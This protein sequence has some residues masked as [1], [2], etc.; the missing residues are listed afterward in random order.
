[1]ALV[2]DAQWLKVLAETFSFVS[3]AQ[4][5][6]FE[7]ARIDEVLAEFA[8]N[9][10]EH[11]R[12]ETDILTGSIDFPPT[13][14]SFRDRHV[15]IVVRGERHR[16]DLKALRAYIRNVRP[17][18]VAVD[19][20]ADGVLEAGMKPDLILGDMD[21]ISDATLRGG[22]EVVVHAYP[23]EET[24][25]LEIEAVPDLDGL[26]V[27]VR[28]FGR[29]ISPRPGVDRPSLRIGLALI[30]VASSRFQVVPTRRSTRKGAET[31]ATEELPND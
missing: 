25:L 1:V 19:G 24:G 2:T 22:A 7:R 8:E 29:G 28:D 27:A 12:Q 23:E 21:S 4:I 11:V 30:A 10:V 5:K 15:L 6:V 14:V 31:E 9:T 16:R 13:R 20:G 18:I 3:P 26:T 17:L